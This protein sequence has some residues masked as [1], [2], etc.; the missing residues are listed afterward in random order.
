MISPPRSFLYLCLS[1][2]NHRYLH[3]LLSVR[4]ERVLEMPP[5]EKV[6]LSLSLCLLG[7]SLSLS[8]KILPH[9][10]THTMS[11]EWDCLTT[12]VLYPKIP[13]N[14]RGSFFAETDWRTTKKEIDWHSYQSKSSSTHSVCMSLL[15][16]THT[17]DSSPIHMP[18]PLRTSFHHD[19]D[20][21]VDDD[22]HHSATTAHK[23]V[24]NKQN[25]W[26][27][28]EIRWIPQLS[29]SWSPVFVYHILVYHHLAV[30]C[31]HSK[32]MRCWHGC[33]LHGNRNE[34]EVGK[35][36]SRDERHGTSLISWFRYLILRKGV[37]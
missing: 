6:S 30:Y 32:R 10:L 13:E 28:M 37:W 7:G 26:I 3:L 19:D 34:R 24:N 18:Y 17:H 22:H 16:N 25:T 23:Y 33:W 4:C 27:R 15:H 9:F 31:V 8:L 20:L 12:H 36:Q 21:F 35:I 1:C 29:S 5:E 14:E 2:D 11:R